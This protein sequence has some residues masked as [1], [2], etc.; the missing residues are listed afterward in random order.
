ML[1]HASGSPV[2]VEQVPYGGFRGKSE[3]GVPSRIY[4]LF[5]IF[6]KVFGKEF[7]KKP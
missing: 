3:E 1:H 7:G 6:G 2:A 4:Y 5:L